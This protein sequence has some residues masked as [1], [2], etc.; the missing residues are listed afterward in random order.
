MHDAR[1]GDTTKPATDT[2][3]YLAEN[4]RVQKI[5][6]CP[7]QSAFTE[8]G[9]SAAKKIRVN[10]LDSSSGSFKKPLNAAELMACLFEEFAS[11]HQ[12]GVCK[13]RSTE[14]PNVWWTMLN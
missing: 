9:P 4:G 12:L 1:E 6:L 3:D 11:H 10:A 14:N 2:M 5:T 7:T 13:I 8:E